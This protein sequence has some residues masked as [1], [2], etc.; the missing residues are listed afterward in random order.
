MFYEF[1]AIFKIFKCNF[2]LK[3]SKIKMR[4]EKSGQP[5]K[6]GRYQASAKVF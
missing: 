6:N 4:G 1:K 5:T 3:I 2:N